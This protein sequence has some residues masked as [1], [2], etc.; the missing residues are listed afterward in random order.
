[1]GTAVPGALAQVGEHDVGA[2]DLV[3]GGAEVIAD[4]AEVGAAGGAVFHEAGGLRLVGVVGGA[5]VDAQLGLQRPADRASMDE[6]DQ[7]PGED[8]GLRA[9]RQ[10]DGQPPGGDVIDRASPAVSFGDAVADELLVLGQV[11][12]RA[13]RGQ[14]EDAF[15][16]GS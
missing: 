16:R 1:M 12:K 13:V 3:A 15:G 7:A 10:P 11:Q 8:R 2:V 4:R 9:G 6:A 5:G 14:P